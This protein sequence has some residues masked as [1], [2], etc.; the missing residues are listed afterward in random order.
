MDFSRLLTS[1]L[2]DFDAGP[3]GRAFARAASI[4][5]AI[6]LSIGQPHFDVPDPIQEAAIRAIREGK[7]RYTVAPGIPPL[8]S[9][10]RSG[11]DAGYK[12]DG[13]WDE[14]GVLVTVGVA[15]GLMLTMLA[16]VQ[17]GD[18]VV[19]PDPYFVMYKKFARLAGG[20]PVF[21]DTYPDFK[22]T[23]ELVEPLITPRTKMLIT[24]SPS[25][26]TGAVTSLLEW[27]ELAELCERRG[28]LIVNDEIY[29][30]F[31]YDPEPGETSCPSP[32]ALTESALILRGFGK[33]WGM[34][35]WRLGYA[36]GPK[37]VV[38]AMTKLHQYLF[39]N[40]PT[41][42][43]HAGIVALQTDVTTRVAEYRRKRDRVVEGL[44][45]DFDLSAPQGAFYAFPKAPRGMSGTR[46]VER[47]ADKKLLLMP[48]GFFS[49]RDTHFRVSFACDDATLDRG[50]ETLIQLAREE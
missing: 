50:I 27:R 46:F 19:M 25:N 15:G 5:D 17:P 42:A 30:H 4:R 6:D 24:S 49:E 47:A 12:R 48:G 28:V 31:H 35:G 1:R 45:Q 37:P 29:R 14:Y 32:A 13:R 7:N 26:P 41:P 40:A 18:E 22:I 10:I 16:C 23:A 44:S 36:I 11:F 33:S 20:T 8:L 9:A 43:Q 38:D 21:V 34:T 2:E 3:L 39:T